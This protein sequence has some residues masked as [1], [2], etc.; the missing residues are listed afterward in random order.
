MHPQD[1][2]ISPKSF[3]LSIKST[4]LA[5][6]CSRLITR[7]HINRQSPSDS[8]CCSRYYGTKSPYKICTPL[9]TPTSQSDYKARSL[10][11]YSS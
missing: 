6:Y 7:C 1:H 10:S 8:V 3:T 5:M 4:E 2:K 11:T 9:F